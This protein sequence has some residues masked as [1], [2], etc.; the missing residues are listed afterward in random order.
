MPT[1]FLLLFFVFLGKENSA[2]GDMTR[3]TTKTSR[4]TTISRQ[5][6]K[7]QPSKMKPNDDISR[8]SHLLFYFSS[9]ASFCLQTRQ[10]KQTEKEQKKK[11]SERT[12]QTT[13]RWQ[14]TQQKPVQQNE[15]KQ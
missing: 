9:F 3:R 13:E 2:N 15:T 11:K 14:P 5:R 12:K 8:P 7:N 6:N 1:L 10:L 4:T